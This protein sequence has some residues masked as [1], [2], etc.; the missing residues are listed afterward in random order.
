MIGVT[1]A[2]FASSACADQGSTGDGS[3]PLTGITWILDVGSVEALIGTT[4]PDARATIRFEEDGQTGG[5]SGCNTF[6][7]T[8]SA[9]DDGFIAIEVG[10]MTEM[11]CEEPLMQLESAYVAALGSVDS[12]DVAG[13]RSEL[14]LTGEDI[15]LTFV[16]ER[17]LPLEGTAWR[18]DAIATGGDAVSSTSAGSEA[19]LR[20]EGDRVSG[21]ASCNQLM[22]AYE[23]DGDAGGG[24]IAFSDIATTRKL[25][26]GPVMDQEH[27]VLSALEAAATYS[28]E[29]ST[30]ALADYDGAFLLSLV[31]S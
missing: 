7:G 18:V 1:V 12:S 25:C 28:I 29:G 8:Y 31:G 3:P 13:D 26:S 30:L 16:A 14:T 5:S 4:A 21:N 11:A 17:P 27:A 2:L 6:G 20:L 19:S 15:A 24:T 22:G 23:I 10:S 9:G